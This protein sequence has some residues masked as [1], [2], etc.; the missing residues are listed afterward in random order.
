[1]V[2]ALVA[3]GCSRVAEHSSGATRSSLPTSAATPTPSATPRTLPAS[4]ALDAGTYL[5]PR[6]SGAVAFSFTVPAGWAT[7]RDGFVSTGTG[8]GTVIRLTSGVIL[9]AYTVDHVYADACH[10]PGTLQ[11]VGDSVEE[12]ATALV[13]QLGRGTAGPFAVSV[14]GYAGRRVELTAPA[15]L[16]NCDRGLLRTWSDLGGDET[17]GWPA[18]PGQTDEVYIVDVNGTRLVIVAAHWADTTPQ[19]LTQ[20]Q[21]VLDSIRIE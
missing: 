21:H 7:D 8:G 13:T 20:L 3:I 4:G 11:P 5:M 9:A 15:D 2:A 17:G 18:A 10:P 1:M 12:L 16:S 14:D 6:T 19:D